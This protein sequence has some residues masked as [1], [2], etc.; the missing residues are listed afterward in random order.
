MSIE[1]ELIKDDVTANN[2][3]ANAPFLQKEVI[4][5]HADG[6]TLGPSMDE[7]KPN[8]SKIHW[9]IILDTPRENIRL[10][11]ESRLNERTG[12]H[13]VLVLKVLDYF[14]ISN[15]VVHRQ[16]FSRKCPT[17]KVQHIL[18]LVFAQGWHKYKMLTTS[19]GAKKGC[20]HHIQTMLVGF[21]SRNWIDSQSDTSKSVEKFL[22][23]VYTRYTDDSRKISIEKRPIDIGR[24]L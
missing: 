3:A 15:N 8:T 7:D 22:P 17:I 18:D 13:G 24:F 4:K 23:F 1:Y 9:A 5:F 10:S 2:I 14:G 19:N 20:R 6:F 21:Q 16:P 11:M 12:K